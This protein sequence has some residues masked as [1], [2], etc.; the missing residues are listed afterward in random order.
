MFNSRIPGGKITLP[1]IL[2]RNQN[3]QWSLKRTKQE[4]TTKQNVSIIN[5]LNFTLTIM[6]LSVA[7]IQSNKIEQNQFVKEPTIFVFSANGFGTI[8]CWTTILGSKLQ[9]RRNAEKKKVFLEYKSIVLLSSF[10]VICNALWGCSYLSEVQGLVL[11]SFCQFF[12]YFF[13]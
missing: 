3:K 12:K 11:L 4:W 13:T 5:I 2:W 9:K 6:H 8:V 1:M 10:Y 7:F